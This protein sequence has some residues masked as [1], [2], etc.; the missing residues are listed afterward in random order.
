MFQPMPY[1]EP[2]PTDHEACELMTVEDWRRSVEAGAYT[3]WDG[4]GHPAKDGLMDI[5]RSC[6][7]DLGNATHVA[8][9]NK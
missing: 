9:F 3:A 8:W 5:T 2:V 7:G 6:F 1:T 4:S